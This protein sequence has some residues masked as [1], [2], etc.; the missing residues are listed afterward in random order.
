MQQLR[1]QKNQIFEHPIQKKR[2]PWTM[3]HWSTHHRCRHFHVCTFQEQ[4]TRWFLT[5]IQ[6]QNEDPLLH[7][8]RLQLL[9]EPFTEISWYVPPIDVLTL[10]CMPF[11]RHNTICNVL[12][13]VKSALLLLSGIGINWHVLTLAMAVHEPRGQL[14]CPEAVE[15]FF[16]PGGTDPQRKCAGLLSTTSRK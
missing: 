11:R 7:C 1:P 15:E 10:V 4:W 12:S 13:T 3:T 2:Q 5:S 8:Q 6:S 16:W 9:R 14:L